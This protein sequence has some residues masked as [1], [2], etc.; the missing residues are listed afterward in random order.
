MKFT[1]KLGGMTVE[2]NEQEVF[3]QDKLV[4][5]AIKLY[6]KKGLNITVDEIVQ[7]AGVT[8]GMFF[9]YFHAKE[10]ILHCISKAQK[11]FIKKRFAEIKKSSG[12][13]TPKIA[14]L[15]VDLA[16]HGNRSKLLV[17][18]IFK[19][20][21]NDKVFLEKEYE[22]SDYLDEALEYMF[23]QGQRSGEFTTLISP[24][25]MARIARQQY[26]GVLTAWCSTEENDE[27]EE[28]VR[29][30]FAMLF[31]GLLERY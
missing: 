2:R 24:F 9:H 21:L 4:T 25:E 18:S 28:K 7:N 31:N 14:Q 13:F 29:L 3:V 30:A 22:V 15:F 17:Q 6:S 26:L 23:E 19:A 5:E 11:K 12:P 16:S 1:E 10:D 8:K 20:S 27:L